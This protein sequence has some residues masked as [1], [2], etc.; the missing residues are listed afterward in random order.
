MIHSV[1]HVLSAI[2]SIYRK[3]VPLTASAPK[4]ICKFRSKT[5]K[6]VFCVDKKCISH[7]I[8]EGGFKGQRRYIVQ[9]KMVRLNAS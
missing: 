2:V 3:K 1:V 5:Y 7:S 4:K 6:F 9:P 8:A